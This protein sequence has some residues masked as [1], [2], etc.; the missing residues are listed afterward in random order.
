VSLH[1]SAE[2]YAFHF[3]HRYHNSFSRATPGAVVIGGD[4]QGLAIVRSLGRH[5]VPAIIV[6][7]EHSIGRFSRY[8][9]CSVQVPNLRDEQ[10]TLDALFY[11]GARLGLE[12]WVLFPTRD[13]TVATLSR[14]RD[15]LAAFY[16]VPTPA[17]STIE[18]AW[19]KR[20]TYRLAGKLG[21]PFPRAYTIRSGAEVDDLEIDFPV[22]LKPAIKEHFIYATKA[23]AWRASNQDELRRRFREASALIGADEVI[24][25]E[26][27]PGDGSKQFAYCAFFK[28]GHDVASMVAQ[29]RRQHPPEFGR[30]STYV[31]TVSVPEVE[32]LATQFLAA[33]DYYGLVEVEFKHDSRNGEFKLLDVNA[34]TWGYHSIG[35]AAGLDF[36]SLLYDDQM[37]ETVAT[38]QHAALGVRWVRIV[39]DLPT[40]IIEI[41][42][43]RLGV[44]PYL[45][46]LRECNSEAVWSRKDPLPGLVE[47]ALIPYLAVKRG[48]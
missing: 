47:A 11:I 27:I 34:R 10:A 26:L 13:E 30:A 20:E 17:W 16:R 25:Q 24:V 12:G 48:F 31:E 29:R 44:G 18:A 35:P 19:D 45:R 3:H 4:Y 39:T 43:K 14:H 41:T 36:P 37:G 28:D 21:I 6:D 9:C 42:R 15:D 7:D 2:P 40:A 22:A 8:T 32:Q 38:G 33:V 23:K 46:S 1:A 5:G